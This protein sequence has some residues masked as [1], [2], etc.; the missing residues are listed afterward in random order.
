[1]DLTTNFDCLDSEGRLII[2]GTTVKYIAH[3]PFGIVQVE[4]PDGEQIK[5]PAWAFLALR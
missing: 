2:S 1:M 5:I 3:L 4:M